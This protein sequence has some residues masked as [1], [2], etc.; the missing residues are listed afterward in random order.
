MQDEIAT[1]N[2]GAMGPVP[3]IGFGGWYRGELD[4]AGADGLVAALRHAIDHGIAVVDTAS[5]YGPDGQS[6]KLIGRAIAGRREKVLLSTKFGNRTVP[7]VTDEGV[8]LQHLGGG[9]P[10]TTG[11]GA[12]MRIANDPDLIPGYLETSLRRLGV[13]YVDLYSPHYPDPGVPI[14]EVVGAIGDLVTAGKVRYVGLS[15]VDA[16]LLRRAHAE[17]PIAVVQNQYSLVDRT[18]ETDALPVARELGT[19]FIASVPLARGDAPGLAE[20]AAKLGIGT[21]QLALAW[22]LRRA[23]DI[24][25]IPGM[26]AEVHVDRNLEALTMTLDADAVAVLE[27][28]PQKAEP[29]AWLTEYRDAMRAAG[30]AGFD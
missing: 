6:E 5:N 18:A 16:E 30:V 17:H 8:Q 29:R 28:V 13:D 9:R 23:P 4:S 12:R 19:G 24:V 27:T 22:L 3:E 25:P 10:L 21:H 14:E 20:L 15:N 2:L 1:R 7:L 26:Q 11:A